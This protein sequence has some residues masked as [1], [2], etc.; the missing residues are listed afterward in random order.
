MLYEAEIRARRAKVTKDTG[1]KV[2]RA[3]KTRLS[4]CPT[5]GSVYVGHFLSRIGTGIPVLCVII[6]IV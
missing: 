4:R 5:Q 6:S 1:E 2:E 3:I